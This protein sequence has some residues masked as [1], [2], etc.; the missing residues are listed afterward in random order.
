RDCRRRASRGGGGARA[1]AGARLLLSLGW[2]E[3]V[4]EKWQWRTEA[5]GWPLDIAAQCVHDNGMSM[6]RP[7]KLQHPEQLTADQW[8]ER[9][10]PDQYRILREAATE[11]PFGQIYEEFEAH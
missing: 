2:Q 6:H 1:V 7:E 9:L 4:E 10:T 5:S 11:R 3:S 8:R